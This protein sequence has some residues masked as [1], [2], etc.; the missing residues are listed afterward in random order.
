MLDQPIVRNFNPAPARRWNG[1]NMKKL[2]LSETV[3]IVL[4]LGFVTAASAQTYS[5]LDRFDGT[6]GHYPYSPLVQGNNGSLYGTTFYGGTHTG[7]VYQILPTGA[8]STLYNFCSRDLGCTDG[9]GPQGNLLLGANGNFY[10][11]AQ[12]G[13]YSAG[14]IFEITPTGT[15]TNLYSFCALRNCADG[16][17]PGQL[18][19]GNDGNFYGTTSSGGRYNQGSFF[20]IT[21]A[22]K[23][24]TLSYFKSS[25]DYPNNGLVQASDGNFYGTN[26]VV[27]NASAGTG[28]GV[29]VRLT[30][31]GIL[32]IVHTFCAQGTPCSD[33]F[34][35]LGTLLQASDGNLYGTAQAGGAHNA[36][37]FFKINASGKFTTLYNFCSQ[38]NCADGSTPISGVLQASDGNFYGVTA[39]GG[40]GSNSNCYPQNCGTI[41]RI[42]PTGVL[43]TLYDFCPAGGKTCPDGFNPQDWS[44]SLMQATDGRIFGTT[45]IGGRDVCVEFAGCGTVYSLSLGLPPILDALP[46]F[47]KAGQSLTIFGDDLTGATA[48]SFNGVPATSFK[49]VSS[50][51]IKAEVPTGTPSGRIQVTTPNGPLNS[52]LEFR[53]V[54]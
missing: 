31:A 44:P 50:T 25:A 12:G 49:V 7:T 1:V 9:W 14:T 6:D 37:T 20:K 4:V 26:S 32:S 8:L 47:G 41:Y 54:P 48:V 36:G 10:G 2:R 5:V 24:T 21:P 53:V 17:A 22:G 13:D 18:V 39:Y 29:V 52:N 30:P 42:T 15:L 16:E 34:F 51:E 23:L 45:Q 19:Q 40:T 28:S 43:T 27:V 3:L 46:N 33:G 38:A 35:P 11:T